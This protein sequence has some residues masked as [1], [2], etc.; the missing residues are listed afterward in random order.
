MTAC[1]APRRPLP[2]PGL[3]RS[4]GRRG[5]RDV[6][7]ADRPRHRPRDRAARARGRRGDR[8]APTGS[9]ATPSPPAARSS[10]TSRPSFRFADGL[11][12]DHVDEFDFRRWAQ[13]GARPE[14]PPGRP[15]AAAAHEGPRAKRCDQLDDLH[16]ARRDR[17][18]HLRSAASYANICSYE[19][20][21]ATSRER[22]A[23][24][25]RRRRHG[26]PHLRRAGGDGDQLPRGPRP[27]GA[28]PRARRPLRLQL[29]DQ[30]VPRLH[31]CL[32]FL[33]RPPHPHLSRPRRRPGL[34]A[35]DRRQGQRAGAAA[36][37]AGAAELEAGAG[38]AG[39]EH[40]PLPV[41]REPLPDDARDPR[42]A[43]GGA[44]RRSR[45]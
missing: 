42:G 1:Y 26:G 22:P 17:L 16:A 35:R 21:R 4:R 43:G 24:A 15:A 23:A 20:G 7:D 11:I 9:P 31:P 18:Q 13:P 39:D 33:L 30:P 27:L 44:R 28:Q 19:V 3:R 12:A 34:R 40:R 14:R 8:H 2:R 38:R 36:G 5:R 25:R 37:G 45:S 10:T 6:A 29:D 32:R 41:G